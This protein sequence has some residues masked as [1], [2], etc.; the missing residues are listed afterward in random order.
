LVRIGID[1][2][3]GA[4][5]GEEF[6]ISSSVESVTFNEVPKAL[7]D[8]RV[9][10][11]DVRRNGERHASHIA[12]TLHI[13]FHELEAR[14]SELPKNKEIWVHCAGA[15]RASAAAGMLERAGLTP[16][17]INEGYEKALGVPELEIVAGGSDAGPVAPSDQKERV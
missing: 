16:V 11:L 8:E 4:Y 14:A 9:V 6:G 3:A 1:R 12:G 7:K 5:I 10:V 13:P 15:Y 2:P 17:L